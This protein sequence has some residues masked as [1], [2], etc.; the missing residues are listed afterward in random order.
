[1]M[2]SPSWI[3]FFYKLSGRARINGRVSFMFRHVPSPS[4]SKGAGVHL[5]VNSSDFPKEL[6]V[7]YHTDLSGPFTTDSIEFIAFLVKKECFSFF[8]IDTTSYALCMTDV[9]VRAPPLSGCVPFCMREIFTKYYE[10]LESLPTENSTKVSRWRRKFIQQ[11]DDER[12]KGPHGGGS[13]GGGRR[14]E[15]QDHEVVLKASTNVTLDVLNEL[16]VVSH[17]P[18]PD[19]V[20]LPLLGVWYTPSTLEW[21]FPYGGRDLY[22]VFLSQEEYEFL[23][24]PLPL[25]CRLALSMIDALKPFHTHELVHGDV[26]LENFLV[27]VSPQGRLFRVLL[28]DYSTVHGAFLNNQPCEGEET[29][30]QPIGRLTC[31]RMRRE[32]FYEMNCGSVPYIDPSRYLLARPSNDG[33]CEDIYSLGICFFILY[34]GVHPYSEDEDHYVEWMRKR[35]SYYTCPVDFPHEDNVSFFLRRILSWYPSQRPTLHEI[36]TFFSTLEREHKTSEEIEASFWKR[37][38]RSLGDN[39]T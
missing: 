37:L 32:S 36:E 29:V 14:T 7:R 8:P 2:Y 33:R 30:A 20:P 9:P 27:S 38:Q 6:F 11:K 39:P 26:K 10:C 24:L 21:V 17:L 22:E 25:F 23:P 4:T 18:Y 15:P 28:C 1:M 19:I 5:I 13:Y 31:W 3:D 12:K 34:Y 35:H 16:W